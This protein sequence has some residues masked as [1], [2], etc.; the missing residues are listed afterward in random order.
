MS[1]WLDWLLQVW[2]TRCKLPTQCRTQA[3]QPQDAHGTLPGL[4]PAFT[5]NQSLGSALPAVSAA[6]KN[7]PQTLLEF[8]LVKNG[9]DP[10]RF[11][12]ILRMGT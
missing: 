12:Q 9:I 3:L 11:T 10:V 7:T 5:P 1:G 8:A 2:R 6:P 4:E